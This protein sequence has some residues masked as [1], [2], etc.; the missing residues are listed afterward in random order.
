[1]ADT[2]QFNAWVD[3]VVKAARNAMYAEV[4]EQGRTITEDIRAKAPRRTGRLQQS[5]R[6]EVDQAKRRVV[7]RA[8]GPLTTV[9]VR[10][11]Q[12]AS[13]DYAT[14]QEWGTQKLSAH[15]FFYPTW[16]KDRPI[17]ARAIVSKIKRAIEG[18]K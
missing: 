18:V 7:I 3:L 10:R 13:Y 1:M 16:R 6:M 12:T 5:V 11:G 15:P 4:L 9:P 2:R 8:G 17:A 14:A